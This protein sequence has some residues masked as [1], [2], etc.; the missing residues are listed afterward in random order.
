MPDLATEWSWNEDG[1]WLTFKLR[2]GVKWHDG[3]PFTAEDVKCT[4]DLCWRVGTEKLR[5]NP[6]KAWYRNLDRGHHQRR[7]RG[8][9]PPEA[10]AAGLYAAR[11]RLLAGLSLPCA[12]REM[13]Q[14]PIG[15]GPFK[16]V[17]YKAQP[18]HQG[19]PQSRLLGPGRPYLDG[20]EWTIIKNRSD[21][22]PGLCLWQIRHDV[23]VLHPRCRC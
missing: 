1:T 11:L 21:R 17:E 2:Q 10:A 8:D 16:F 12:A 19:D 18:I 9:L 23:S 13:R 7:P 22:D 15:T 5:V 3:K 14:H 20:I 4:W 6:R